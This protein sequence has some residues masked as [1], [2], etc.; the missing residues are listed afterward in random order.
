VALGAYS[1]VLASV[2]GEYSSA[3]IIRL[4]LADFE[5][6]AV[7]TILRFLYTTEL[8]LNCNIVGQV[9]SS[10]VSFS[11]PG[12]RGHSLTYSLLLEII[13]K[14]LQFITLLTAICIVSHIEN[15]KN[16]KGYIT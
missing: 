4:D 3:D 14:K 9:R 8:H 7:V 10:S 11:I 1:D 12:P 13:E 15:S 5:S 2:L 16:D 6:E